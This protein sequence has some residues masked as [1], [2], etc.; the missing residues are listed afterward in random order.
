MCLL[1]IGSACVSASDEKLIE[2]AIG[3]CGLGYTV[4]A[5]IFSSM[6]R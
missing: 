3:E 4:G 1:W 5:F 6:E 2:R